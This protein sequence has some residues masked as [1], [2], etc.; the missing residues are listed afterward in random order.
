MRVD[1]G[2][3]KEGEPGA[4]RSIYRGTG[5]SGGSKRRNTWTTRIAQQRTTENENLR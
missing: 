3:K 5:H 1:V 2:K 4:R